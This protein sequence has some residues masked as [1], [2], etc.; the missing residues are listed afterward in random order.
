MYIPHSYIHIRLTCGWYTPATSIFIYALMWNYNTKYFNIDIPRACLIIYCRITITSYDVSSY[1]VIY[2]FSDRKM[3]IVETMFKTFQEHPNMS[4]THMTCFRA[5]Y[6]H[7]RISDISIRL[8]FLWRDKMI[9]DYAVY[10]YIYMRI[11]THQIYSINIQS[12][13][14]YIVM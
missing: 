11:Y 4:E 13:A 8:T 3:K 9:Y 10:A 2:I 6:T 5:V 12:H 7:Y 14:T 1:P